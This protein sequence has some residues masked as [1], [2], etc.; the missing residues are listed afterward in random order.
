GNFVADPQYG[1]FD[2]AHWLISWGVSRFDH[3]NLATWL[4]CSLAVVLLGLGVWAVLSLYR[5]PPALAAAASLGVA[6]T[7]FFLWFGA[8]WWPLLWSTAWLPWLWYGMATKGRVGV[9]LTGVSAYLIIVSGCP[10]NYPFAAAI[11]VA[12]LIER[13]LSGGVPALWARH[14]TMRLLAGLGGV[15]ASAPTILS[16]VQMLP[17]TTRQFGTSQLG[18]LGTF[19]PNLGDV[20]IGGSTLTPGISEFWGGTLVRAPIA[21]TA[22]FALPAVALVSWRDVWRRPGVLTAGLLLALGVVATQAPTHLGPLRFPFRYLVVVGVFLPVLVALGLTYARQV[23]KPRLAC[24]GGLLVLQLV[25][26]TF[27]APNLAL[28]HLVALLIGVA[29]TGAVVA[30]TIGTTAP[31]RVQLRRAM[32]A[33]APFALVLSSFGGAVAGERSAEATQAR[34][35]AAL[36][37]RPTGW[38]ARS[39]QIRPDWGSTVAEFRQQSLLSDAEASVMAWKVDLNAAVTPWGA[40][41][42]AGN[43]N[44]F[45][46]FQTGVGYWASAQK[47]WAERACIDYIGQ[48]QPDPGCVEGMLRAVPDAGGKAWIDLVSLDEVLLSPA[49]PD[50]MRAHFEGSWVPAG[51]IGTSGYQ[52]FL[53]PPSERLPGRVTATTGD[54]TALELRAGSG[55]PAYGGKPF[56]SYV[57]SSG[58]SGG[59]L[60]LRV[61]YWPGLRATLDG[62]PLPV[63]P[64]EGTLTAVTLPP[65]ID[66]G[67]LRMEFR[68]IGERILTLSL[69]LA[70]LLIGAAAIACGRGARS[71]DDKAAL[72]AAPA[73]A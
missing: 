34:L 20:I 55:G 52:R 11:V 18:N 27:R 31:H 66:R 45:S 73:P 22:A 46:D 19:I 38:P 62:R 33:A 12:Q 14:V 5:C 70:I 29:A 57:V 4:L 8:S 37:Q 23:T 21:A 61:P 50:E 43:A 1:V 56:D 39:L 49:T 30:L 26:A 68:P 9:V 3:L 71:A 65:G 48:F 67:T 7:G 63:E 25:L 47:R 51:L 10:Y 2:P 64:V 35:E 54:A 41:V 40:G 53:R 24:A 16:G 42:V 69:A 15:V 6:S 72:A 28:W 13:A 36:G 32:A 44:L 17:L 58:S 59:S 60:V